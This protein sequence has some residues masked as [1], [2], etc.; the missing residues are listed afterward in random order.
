MQW[1]MIPLALSYTLLSAHAPHQGNCYNA[2]N[3]DKMGG[4]KLGI[5]V[6]EMCPNFA[7]APFFRK[8][9]GAMSL[10]FW[11]T[12]YLVGTYSAVIRSKEKF[13][14]EWEV[15][16]S[17]KFFGSQ[18]TFK[19]GRAE[20]CEWIAVQQHSI[21]ITWAVRVWSV[22]FHPATVSFESICFFFCEIEK[23]YSKFKSLWVKVRLWG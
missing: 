22:T 20:N 1:E 19:T 13:A 11:H 3:T 18:K 7:P 9:T 21:I 16:N 23:K 14:I 12:S 6:D 15:W 17:R 8:T 5:F 4:P 10:A 2:D